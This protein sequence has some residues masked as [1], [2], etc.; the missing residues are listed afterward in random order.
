LDGIGTNWNGKP[1]LME[2]QGVSEFVVVEWPQNQA[3][4]PRP[5]PSHSTD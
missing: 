3:L 1:D 5:H 4:A 2:K